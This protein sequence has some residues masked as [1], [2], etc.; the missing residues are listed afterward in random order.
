[1]F[2]SDL[3]L[4]LKVGDKV[5]I[6]VNDMS[7]AEKRRIKKVLGADAPT[8]PSY[9][10]T[11]AYFGSEKRPKSATVT[12]VTSTDLKEYLMKTGWALEEFAALRQF[13]MQPP[14][15]FQVSVVKMAKVEILLNDFRK[16]GEE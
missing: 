16:L 8:I 15:E 1:M 3:R 13:G 4:F 14:Q 6:Q 9:M 2:F 12:P 11:L 10:A 5:C 7:S